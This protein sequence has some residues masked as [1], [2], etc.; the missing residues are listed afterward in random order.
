[1][2]AATGESVYPQDWLRIAAEDFKRVSRR[3]EEGDID[4]AAFRLQQAIE[5]YLKGYLLARGWKLKR[6]HDVE[7]LLTA[8]VRH[9]RALE[10]YRSLCQQVAGYYIIE[11]YPMFEEGPSLDEV[12]GAY[13]E[14]KAL[15]RHLRA[16]PPRAR[17]RRER[18][19]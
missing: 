6:I 11:R 19:Q 8:A 18:R 5:K 10:R 2:A 17:R 16:Q 12:R 15:V 3:L 1:M 13:E 14:A 7:S 9:D 4:D